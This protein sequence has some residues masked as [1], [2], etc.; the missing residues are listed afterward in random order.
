MNGEYDAQKVCSQMLSS[1]DHLSTH[2]FQDQGDQRGTEGL[3][4]VDFF[5][6]TEKKSV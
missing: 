3:G 1:W 6:E 4:L 5:H 2:L